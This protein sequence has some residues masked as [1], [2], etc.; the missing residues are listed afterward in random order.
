M[1]T[2][3]GALLRD[4]LAMNAGHG[5]VRY[6]RCTCDHCIAAL[7]AQGVRVVAPDALRAAFKELDESAAFLPIPKD[8]LGSF[9]VTRFGLAKHR[10]HVLLHELTNPQENAPDGTAI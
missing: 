1:L 2:P 5:N 7:V 10:I 8:A 9:A 3:L 6:L 4:E